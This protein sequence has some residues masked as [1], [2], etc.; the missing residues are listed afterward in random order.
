MPQFLTIASRVRPVP[1]VG[2]AKPVLEIAQGPDN[3]VGSSVFGGCYRVYLNHCGARD[4]KIQF[5]NVCVGFIRFKR[6][7]T[8]KG[9]GSVP[10]VAEFKQDI[11]GTPAAA[12]AHQPRTGF[13]LGTKLPSHIAVERTAALLVGRAVEEGFA[14]VGHQRD[15]DCIEYCRF[16]TSVVANQE[17]VRPNRKHV[18]LEVIPLDQPYRL[19]TPH[20][21]DSS[22][23]N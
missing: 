16:S 7:A 1:P 18:I 10:I 2:L 20:S 23:S 3:S 12:K 4:Q 9:S 22:S 17:T 6:D 8:S 15:L 14:G 21:P 11:G 13:V 5:C 19:Q